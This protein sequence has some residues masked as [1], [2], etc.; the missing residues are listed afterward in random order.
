MIEVKLSRLLGDKRWNQSDLA[1][2]ADVR[3]NTVSELY[4]D[5][6]DRV[7]LDQL[8]RICDVLECDLSELLVYTPNTKKVRKKRTNTKPTGGDATGN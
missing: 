8:D 1:K 4:N 3:P 2:R 5:F 6:A 7:S